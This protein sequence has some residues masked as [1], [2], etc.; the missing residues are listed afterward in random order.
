MSLLGNETV[1]FVESLSVC[2]SDVLGGGEALTTCDNDSSI[3]VLAYW[4]SICVTS[5]DAF[6]EKLWEA[7]KRQNSCVV[8]F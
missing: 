3:T 2:E 8:P 1:F 4:P 7:A 6:A 5:D